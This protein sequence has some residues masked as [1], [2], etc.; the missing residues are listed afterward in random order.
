MYSDSDSS[1]EELL[2]VAPPTIIKKRNQAQQKKKRKSKFKGVFRCGKKFKAQ[3]QTNGVQHY[4]GLFDTE[5]EAARSYDEHAKAVLGRRARS[6]FEYPEPAQPAQNV[7]T[8]VSEE[9]ISD[10]SKDRGKEISER[11]RIMHSKRIYVGIKLKRK[12]LSEGATLE[13]VAVST[14]M[15]GIRHDGSE[16]SAKR[17]KTAAEDDRGVGAATSVLAAPAVAHPPS[18]WREQLYFW[19]GTIS[20]DAQ[21]SCL[22]WKGSWLGYFNTT[23]TPEQL[24][25]SR[26]FF[27]Y[28]GP[29]AV[30]SDV[31]LPN[32]GLRPLSGAFKGHY[33]MD[34]NGGG[35]MQRFSDKS[36][37][38]D[39]QEIPGSNPLRY[40]VVGKGDS[41]FGDFVVE[42]I[43]DSSTRVLAASRRY[44]VETDPLAKSTLQELKSM[45]GQSLMTNKPA[46]Q[47]VVEV[48]V[49]PAVSV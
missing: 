27:E 17:F 6:N 8:T 33:M 21:N 44:V 19:L 11:P 9:K 25:W 36:C 42:G 47:P 16:V 18:D 3:I 30:E 12:R 13:E 1:I 37:S 10:P 20:V 24:Q 35:S 29:S 14:G 31:A 49:L 32:G 26:N 38:L 7:S 2:G 41:E 28:S 15:T 4:L 43:Y 46:H 45:H 48:Q 34:N 5:E 22:V 40:S 39:F 23:P